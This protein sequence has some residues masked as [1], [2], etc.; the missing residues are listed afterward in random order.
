MGIGAL[1][2]DLVRE[3][4]PVRVVVHWVRDILPLVS[5]ACFVVVLLGNVQL[6]LRRIVKDE[7]KIRKEGKKEAK[8]GEIVLMSR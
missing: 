5:F 7:G 2:V 1:P 3:E 8:I 6:K 4:R